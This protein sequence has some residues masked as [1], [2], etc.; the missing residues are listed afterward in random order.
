MRSWVRWPSAL[1]TAAL[2]LPLAG[3]CTFL[4]A[5]GG[6]PLTRVEL[7]TW[8][9]LPLRPLPDRHV[10]RTRVRSLRRIIN[11]PVNGEYVNVDGVGF[12]PTRG[13]MVRRSGH[14]W[15]F[16]LPCARYTDVLC[17]DASL[18]QSREFL[19]TAEGWG[20]GGYVGD[21]LHAWRQL[22]LSDV[23]TGQPVGATRFEVFATPLAYMRSRTVWPASPSGKP[24][25]RAAVHLG[26][27]LADV[28]YILKDG[29]TILGGL[30]GWG[31]VNHVRYVQALWLPIPVGR[32]PQQ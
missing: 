6:G 10:V 3:C 23:A 14:P 25:I 16:G 19:G 28:P 13:A 30:V 21:Y 29:T 26:A 20:L 22:T 4:S 5:R 15:V 8:A 24:T 32:V 17:Y 9:D 31:R 27:A 18:K 11:D 2:L 1:A 7:G 12:A